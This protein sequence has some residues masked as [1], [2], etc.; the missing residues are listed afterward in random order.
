MKL[1]LDVWYDASNNNKILTEQVPRKETG[2][3]YKS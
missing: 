1:E 2:T 3:E